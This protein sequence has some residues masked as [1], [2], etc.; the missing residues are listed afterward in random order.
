MSFLF[1]FPSLHFIVLPIYASTP[2]LQLTADCVCVQLASDW[3]LHASH[4]EGYNGPRTSFLH[5]II[6]YMYISLLSL[7]VFLVST[8]NL[9]KSSYHLSNGMN[10]SPGTQQGW[11]KQMNFERSGRKADSSSA[12]DPVHR[13]GLVQA[14]LHG[15]WY[16]YRIRGYAL[17]QKTLIRGYG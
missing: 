3:N 6:D 12:E 7:V 1:S 5:R 15:Y 13:G 2:T 16:G 11:T 8:D 9:Q 17:S 14:M 10:S 4:A